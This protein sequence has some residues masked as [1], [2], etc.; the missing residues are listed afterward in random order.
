LAVILLLW[1]CVPVLSFG[2]SATTQPVDRQTFVT[3]MAGIGKGM[4]AAEVRKILGPPDDIRYQVEPEGG[5]RAVSMR[6]IWCYG[7]SGPETLATL[8][9]VY[10]NQNNEVQYVFGRSQAPPPPRWFKESEL[11]RLLEVIDQA[12]YPRAAQRFDPRKLIR[13]VNTLQP[14]GTDKAISV[15]A[16]YLR[17]KDAHSRRRQGVH[18]LLRALFDLPKGSGFIP[19]MRIGAPDTGMPAEPGQYPYFPLLIVDDVPFMLVGGYRLGGSPQ[20]PESDLD[21]FVENCEVR[22]KPLRPRVDLEGLLDRAMKIAGNLEG[23][24]Y[25]LAPARVADQFIRLTDTVYRSPPIAGDGRI[26]GQDVSVHWEAVKV[27]VATLSV[28]WDAN[29]NR[30]VFA[31]GSTLQAN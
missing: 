11:R 4:S 2:A 25:H 10:I 24:R 12:P 1:P 16:E 14:L 20:S 28:R 26:Y 31:D 30:Y 18:L 5:P 15:I 17:I 3:V 21:F 9:G 27:G 13:A 22:S 7:T 8:G 29:H 6:E 19:T 23:D